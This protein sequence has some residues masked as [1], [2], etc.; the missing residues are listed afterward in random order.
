[1]FS[2]VD[3][4]EQPV[5][6]HLARRGHRVRGLELRVQ[7][8]FSTGRSAQALR[9][10]CVVARLA[11]GEI[12]EEALALKRTSPVEVQAMRALAEL[13]PDV[14]QLPELIASGADG[15]GPWVLLPMYE[16]D[17][18]PSRLLPPP[19]VLD[20][21]ARVHS[22]WEGQTSALS[23]IPAITPEWWRDLCLDYAL[24]RLERQLESR[25]TDA[26]AAAIA[27]VAETADD[28]R[29]ASALELLP[30]TLVH[31]DL[32]AA[33]IVLADP[34]RIIDWDSARLGPA[35]LDVAEAAEHGSPGEARYLATRQR[36]EGRA[37][38][39]ALVTLGYRWAEVQIATQYLHYTAEFRPE[40][41]LA[42]MIR[43]RARALADL[44]RCLR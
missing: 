8:P 44:E 14:P 27:A 16:G 10:L 28:A 1:M 6:E 17:H 42:A 21:I 18:P 32:H 15:E 23:A 40:A 11:S 2:S 30:R 33:N 20:A 38:D 26:V 9:R 22:H 31:G 34:A 29:I 19:E 5:L 13:A 12:L 25:P 4:L 35:M 36:L 24:P 41:E 7:G 39:P 3:H 43:T 37:A